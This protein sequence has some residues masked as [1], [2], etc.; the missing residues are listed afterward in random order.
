MVISESKQERQDKVF[1]VVVIITNRANIDIKET[2]E[3]LIIASGL[4]LSV[5]IV[6]VGNANFSKM[7]VFEEGSEKLVDAE[8]NTA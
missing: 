1:R 3:Q 5:L 6:G 8:C 7:S 2:I 4:P